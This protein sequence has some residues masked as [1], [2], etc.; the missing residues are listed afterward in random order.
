MFSTRFHTLGQMGAF[1]MASLIVFEAINIISEV[2]LEF[3]R[4]I[5][6]VF[7]MTAL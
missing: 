1:M 4:L 5:L 2:V 7:F 6:V 3:A